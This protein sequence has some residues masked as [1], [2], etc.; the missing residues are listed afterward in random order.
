MHALIICC[1]GYYA[2][3]R[4]AEEMRYCIANDYDYS[5]TVDTIKRTVGLEYEYVLQRALTAR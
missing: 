3:H 4:L 1:I 5:L 2:L